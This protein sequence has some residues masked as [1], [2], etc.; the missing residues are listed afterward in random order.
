MAKRL[1]VLAIVPLILSLSNCTFIDY[2]E[3]VPDKIADSWQTVSIS[4]VGTFRVPT[5]WS[6]E[7]QDGN[8]Y[9]T[10]NPLEDGD[11]MI[12]LVG[13][14]SRVESGAKVE[15]KYAQPHELFEGVE[16][17]DILLSPGWSNG[18]RLYLIEYLVNGIK[19]EHHLITLVN[20]SGVKSN[21]LELL[22]WNRDAVDE[23]RAEQIA[24]TFVA[25]RVHFDNPNLVVGELES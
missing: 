11:Y 17:G 10:D 6:V 23:Y 7:Q 21:D 4:G 24:R 25:N 18:A 8:L 3:G 13:A 20:L 19:E 15:T 16:R 5:E 9:I 22:V 14:V 2:L 1:I 12:Y